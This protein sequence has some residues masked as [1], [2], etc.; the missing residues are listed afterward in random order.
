MEAKIQSLIA[1]CFFMIFFSCTSK[2]TKTSQVS[3]TVQMKGSML[4]EKLH[5]E[6]KF[7]EL[8][9]A[10]YGA[11]ITQVSV[12]VNGKV[13][14]VEKEIQESCSEMDKTE[15]MDRGIPDSAI[16]AFSSWWGGGGTVNYIQKVDNKL[17]IYRAFIDEGMDDSP[18]EWKV[19]KEISASEL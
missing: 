2:T 12:I 4:P 14:L 5:I 3:D 6:W 9:Q 11:P 18:I 13:I 7:D 1:I 19:L 8:G 17:F 16:S 10:E 15:Y